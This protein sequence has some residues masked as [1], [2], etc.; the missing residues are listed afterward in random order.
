[1]S[2]ST[3]KEVKTHYLYIYDTSTCVDIRLKNKV[4]SINCELAHN[5]LCTDGGPT[6]ISWEM[7]IWQ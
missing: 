7:V 6:A 3:L 1:M 4:L 2:I 5:K